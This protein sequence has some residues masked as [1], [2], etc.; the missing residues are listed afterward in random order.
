MTGEQDSPAGPVCS[1][2]GGPEAHFAGSRLPR[3][4]RTFLLLTE[5]IFMGCSGLGEHTQTQQAYIPNRQECTL[6]RAERW[7]AG[8]EVG[9]THVFLG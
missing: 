9:A 5:H 3:P 8:G 1:H 6:G 2:P 4:E 7:S